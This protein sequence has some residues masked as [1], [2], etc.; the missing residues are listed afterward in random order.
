MPEG[1]SPE[2]LHSLLRIRYGGKVADLDR[3]LELRHFAELFDWPA[4]RVLIE[5]QL[6]HMLADAG[7]MDAESL[8]AV[9]VHSEESVAMPGH[10]KAAALAA[11]VRQW[12][13]ITSV[14]ET[15]L[16][17]KRRSELDTLSRIRNRDGHVCGSLEE[18]LHAAADDLTEW[19]RGLGIEAPVAARKQVEQAWI[20]WQQILFE[21]GHIFGAS[22]AET[23]RAK[24][25]AQREVLREER[26]MDKGKHMNL[27]AG[28]VW[29]EPT[30]DW[31]EVPQNAI[32]P[33]G[34]EYR[35]DMQTGRNFAR[36]C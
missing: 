33:A 22:G 14:A 7:G 26:S 23:W 30:H 36:L 34:L 2:A 10:L 13:K 12:S 28:R 19:E 20:H 31:R 9:V 8:L 35:F 16:P 29:F 11:A 4:V 18:Y 32:C 21:Y 1:L 6:E 24:V 25:L 5:N 27:P 15:A 3:I 17:K